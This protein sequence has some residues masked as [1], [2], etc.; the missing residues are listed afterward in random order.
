M[1]EVD[2]IQIFSI[3]LSFFTFSHLTSPQVH[4]LS[5]DGRTVR[6]TCGNHDICP[7]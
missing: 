6:F 2:E 1:E 5:M 4:T 7:H 3:P